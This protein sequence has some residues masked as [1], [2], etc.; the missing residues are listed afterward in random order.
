[1]DLTGITV[2]CFTASYVVALGFEIYSLTRRFGWHRPLVLIMAV[3]GTFAHATYLFLRAAGE[4]TPL[5]SP[6]EWYLLAALALAC[7]YVYASFTAPK[8]AIG[9]FLLPLI[10]ALIGISLVVSDKPFTTSRASLF[11]GQ[12]HGWLLLAGAVTVLV[13][14]LAGVMYLIQ[15]W[16]LKKK[17]PPSPGFRLPSLEQLERI[18]SR[19]LGISALLIAGGFVSG[20]VLTRLK[21]L[22]ADGASVWSDPVVITLAVMLGWLVGAEIFRWIY[23][24][25]RRGRKVA[26]LTLASFVF[27]CMTL[28]ALAFANKVHTSG[29]SLTVSYSN[30]SAIR[31]P[32]SAI[33]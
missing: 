17:L 14:F 1:M 29:P 24:A 23:P 33:L 26:Y 11:W 32:Q 4:T 19:S 5:S 8:Q 15:S 9:L 6:A 18:N 31:N 20:I 2:F 22:G 3:A 16:R 10:L 12:V 13:G 28:G 7:V 30:H 27:L 25:A 21:N